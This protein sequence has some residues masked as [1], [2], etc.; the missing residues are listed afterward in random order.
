MARIPGQTSFV[1]L[2]VS[3][4]WTVFMLLVM[5]LGHFLM[6]IWAWE[7]FFQNAGVEELSVLLGIH[8]DVLLAVMAMA[9]ISDIWAH[10]S[11]KKSLEDSIKRRRR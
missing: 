9:V 1:T 8:P 4:S 6:L 3:G 2:V 7:V 5:I 11:A 10:F